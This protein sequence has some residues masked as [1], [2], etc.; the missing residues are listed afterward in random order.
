MKNILIGL[1][2]ELIHQV[3]IILNKQVFE[4]MEQIE[5]FER[6]LIENDFIFVEVKNDI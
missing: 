1:L 3:V 5:I 6:Q 2:S 4:I